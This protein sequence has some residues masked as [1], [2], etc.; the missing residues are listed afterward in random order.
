M[1][2]KEKSKNDEAWEKLFNKYSILEEVNKNG[3]FIIGSA[4]INEFRESR[5]MAKVDQLA[6]LPQIFRANKLSIL[7]VSRSEYIIAPIETHYPVTYSTIAPEPVQLPSYIESIDYSNLYSEAIALNWAFIAGIINEL[8]EERRTFHTVSGRM[9]TMRFNFSI[10]STIT[11]QLPLQVNVDNSQCEIDGG[12]EGEQ[13]FVLVEAKN[14]AVNNFIIRQLYYPYRLWSKKLPKKVIP[15][16]MTFS[17]DVFDFFIYRFA[18]EK[19]YNS[20]ILVEQKRYALAPEAITSSDID[21]LLH[22]ETVSEPPRIPFPQA[23]RFDRVVDLLSLLAV[24]PLTKDEITENYDF[25]ARQTNYYTD[26]GR[27]LGLIN[28]Y[29]DTETQEVTFSLTDEARLILSKKHKQKHLELIRKILEHK[30]Y[31]NVLRLALAQGRIPTQ[32]EVSR[33]ILDSRTDINITTAWRRASTVRG[34]I[35]WIWK[36]IE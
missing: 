8:V 16:L 17:Q 13:Y 33:S 26:A 22:I 25:D 20:L 18:D 19:D 27:Y 29:P 14:Y 3:Q 4:R 7:P 23:D 9:S 1:K 11:G 36:Q 28:K 2:S 30:V 5:L 35:E 10:K 34:W 31:Q 21:A 6:N 24:K 12:F 32:Q 15:V